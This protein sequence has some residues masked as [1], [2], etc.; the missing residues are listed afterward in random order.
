MQTFFRIFIME[1][2]AEMGDK[3]QLMLVAMT[4]KYRLR[5]ILLGTGAAILALNALAVA[6]GGLLGSL[7]PGWLIRICAGLLFILFGLS[8]LREQGEADGAGPEEAAAA[9]THAG[10]GPSAAPL[11]VFLAFFMAELGD[12]TQLAAVSFSAKEGPQNALIVWAACSLG[13][14]AADM[15]GLAAGYLL[16]RKLPEA[17]IRKGAACIFLAYGLFTVITGLRLLPGLFSQL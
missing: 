6:A 14:F 12:K 16:A 13:L 11:A 4:A 15:I 7:I 17:W 5:D 2:A 3:T 8:L 9:D 10:R 1:F